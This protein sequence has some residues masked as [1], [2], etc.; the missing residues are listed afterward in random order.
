MDLL[1]QLLLCL[2]AFTLLVIVGSF[3]FIMTNVVFD[4]ID[5]WQQARER[6]KMNRE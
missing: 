3:V 1:G 6:D 5:E 4:E 2:V